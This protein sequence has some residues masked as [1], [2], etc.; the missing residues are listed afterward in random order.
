MGPLGSSSTGL[1]RRPLPLQA[2]NLQ[3]RSRTVGVWSP[4]PLG[5]SQ[6]G[7]T[8]QEPCGMFHACSRTSSCLR[9]GRGCTR[10]GRMSVCDRLAVRS[11]EA[12]PQ[13]DV[14]ARF[15]FP[16]FLPFFPLPLSPS[17]LSFCQFVLLTLGSTVAVHSSLPHL[18]SLVV[19]GYKI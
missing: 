15:L 6:R 17:L 4:A 11:R 12:G 13:A 14:S 9:L 5:G 1:G 16:F 19:N 3:L 7:Q 8:W 10:G 2:N 18:F